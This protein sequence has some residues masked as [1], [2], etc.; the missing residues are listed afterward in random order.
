MIQYS[1]DAIVGRANIQNVLLGLYNEQGLNFS[2]KGTTLVIRPDTLMPASY[3]TSNNVYSMPDLKGVL[4]LEL[5]GLM[6]PEKYVE[7]KGN[8]FSHNY[9]NWHPIPFV[10]NTILVKAGA[11]IEDMHS[12]IVSPYAKIE[13]PGFYE[14]RAFD[15]LCKVVIK[16]WTFVGEQAHIR[17]RYLKDGV[18]T[19]GPAVIGRNCMPGGACDI[20]PGVVMED[21][22]TVGAERFHGVVEAYTSYAPHYM[23]SEGVIPEPLLEERI[24]LAKVIIDTSH[25]LLNTDYE[26]REVFLSWRTGSNNIYVSPNFPLKENSLEYSDY[27]VRKAVTGNNPIIGVVFTGLSE[28]ISKIFTP[29]N[30][31]RLLFNRVT[32]QLANKV[33]G[34]GALK[35]MLDNLTGM[36]V[37]ENS[38]AGLDTFIDYLHP[39]LCYVGNNVKI[40]PYS[41]MPVHAYRTIKVGS[42]I[43]HVLSLG[44]L[45]ISDD[46][47]FGRTLFYPGTYIAKGKKFGK[48]FTLHGVFS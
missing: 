30:M 26:G 15:D 22:S 35:K 45:H 16:N 33:R 39:E 41:G 40:H 24:K 37:G 7:E 46:C 6:N 13:A 2:K 32:T 12:V 25:R 17:T 21:G 48:N 27:N 42:V 47:E 10:K 9:F 44:I 5:H 8:W 28:G 14:D 29:N 23:H 34:E 36:H 3:I 43:Q 11:K 19:V 31:A 20:G 4:S 1:L 38:D 18:L